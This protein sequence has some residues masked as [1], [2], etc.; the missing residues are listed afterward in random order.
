M[1]KLRFKIKQQAKKRSHRRVVA[2]RKLK[3]QTR[4]HADAAR[5][6]SQNDSDDGEFMQMVRDAERL[7]QHPQTLV[8][9]GARG[10][11]GSAAA[12]AATKKKH[13]GEPARRLT[14]KQQRRKEAAREMGEAVAERLAVRAGDKMQRVK[15]RARIRNS[16]IGN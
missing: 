14:R 13:A 2:K 4:S 5:A 8:S 7:Q 6:A 15:Q 16:D 1:T 11:E 12:A 3:R 10:G 9:S